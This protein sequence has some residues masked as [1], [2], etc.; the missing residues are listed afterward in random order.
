MPIITEKNAGATLLCNYDTQKQGDKIIGSKTLGACTGITVP[1][2]NV[3]IKDNSYSFRAT[4][5]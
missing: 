4:Y 5:N 1:L 2:D 3:E